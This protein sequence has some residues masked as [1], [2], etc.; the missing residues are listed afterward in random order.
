MATTLFLGKSTTSGPG[1][2]NQRDLR[3]TRDSGVVTNTV[4]T[5]VSGNHLEYGSSPD[6]WFIQVNAVT[7]SGT[8]SF[9]FWGNED[10]MTTNAGAACRIARCD[11]SGTELSD[12]VANA[13]AGHADSVEYGTVSAVN[14]WT[15]TPTST[16]FSAGDWLKVIPHADAVG[17]AMAVGVATL[18]YG[19]TTGAA[20]GD[21]FVTFTET[22]TAFSGAAAQVPYTNP[23]I[24]LLPQ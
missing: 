5:T 23:Y 10:A 17:G 3:L 19:G 8:I 14:T 15:A 6:W 18:S 11:S 9:N 13:N 2:A 7:I 24:Q 20:N 12:V 16:T 1:A 22:I 4:S 21:T